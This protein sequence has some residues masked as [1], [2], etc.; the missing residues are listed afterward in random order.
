MKNKKSMKMSKATASVAKTASAAVVAG[1]KNAPAA[2]SSSSDNRF[3]LHAARFKQAPQDVKKVKVDQRF[4]KMFT[5][6]KF[7]EGGSGGKAAVDSRGRPL[8]KEVVNE[9]NGGDR[10]NKKSRGVSSS[11]SQGAGKMK[12]KESSN[13]PINRQLQKFYAL[14][15]ED[16]AEK[17]SS[18]EEEEEE[19][20][21]EDSV[22]ELSEGGNENDAEEIATDDESGSEAGSSDTD[23]SE[24]EDSYDPDDTIWETTGYYDGKQIER[25]EHD[26]GSRLAF[27]TLDWDTVTA[28]DIF[29]V[30]KSFIA[31]SGSRN[32]STGQSGA[33]TRVGKKLLNAGKSSKGETDHADGENSNLTNNDK[34]LY[35]RI[36]RS[37]TGEKALE[38]EAQHGP[39]IQE[40]K[41][42]RNTSSSSATTGK[43][44]QAKEGAGAPVEDSDD[45]EME[46]E[47]DKEIN[48]DIN[49]TND[50]NDSSSSE[51]EE[52]QEE[53]RKYNL[54][55]LQYFFAVI[56]LDSKETCGKLYEE[57]DGHQID[58]LC[59]GRPLDV[60][61]VPDEMGEIDRPVVDECTSKA[62]EETLH[63]SSHN[64][65]HLTENQSLRAGLAHTKAQC[66]WDEQP[67]RRKK[68][69]MK[70]FSKKE[71]ALNDLQTYLADSDSEEDENYEGGHLDE[72]EQNEHDSAVGI[73]TSSRG[74]KNGNAGAQKKKKLSKEVEEKRKLLLGG[75][76]KNAEEEDAADSSPENDSSENNGSEL[77]EEE[78]S[79]EIDLPD[80]AAADKMISAEEEDLPV[81][82]EE[83][84]EEEDD[85][86]P[87]DFSV[88]AS[89]AEN[90]TMGAMEMTFNTETEAVAK[91]VQEKVDEQLKKNAGGK[92]NLQNMQSLKLEQ[93]SKLTPWQKFQE[94]KKEKRREKKLEIK[95]KREEI[96]K[97]MQEELEQQSITAMKGKT[98]K[99][100]KKRK[101]DDDS[102][103]EDFISDVDATQEAHST[104]K[105]STATKEL[106]SDDRFAKL[107]NDPEFGIDPTRPEFND[108][109][110]MRAV[111]V[112]KRK[113]AAKSGNRGKKNAASGASVSTTSSKPQSANNPNAAAATQE[114]TPSSSGAITTASKKRQRGEEAVGEKGGEKKNKF[115]LFS[116]K[117]KRG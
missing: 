117:Q 77:E 54:R 8:K 3:N 72:D 99:K 31:N 102:S 59:N 12:M 46:N 74:E 5:E 4:A 81:L 89:D 57:L 71:M 13:K 6:E 18:D 97:A 40:M 11:I 21:V 110:T 14:E 83:E 107:F 7:N 94:K 95:D 37:E 109:K 88:A 50:D 45:E 79:S 28:E 27:Q 69:L 47:D 32:A 56:Q 15:R 35:C 105:S 30:A 106:A 76:L 16:K 93:A 53:I 75:L 66:N 87:S 42:K 92:K 51:N 64:T 52:Q 20:N 25:T 2:S 86:I 101:N 103:E 62:F 55:K 68:D 10:K 116:K 1:G 91:K 70:K 39:A 84:E 60:R 33:N 22:E 17:V 113:V 36:Y 104:T 41:K 63:K 9:V 23:W 58:S 34:I 82:E 43:N 26:T 114:S 98:K 78:G 24:S 112:E 85:D 38:Y 100:G 29:R 111:L 108:T 67:A 19:E 115:Q 48:P 49:A 73:S 96:K 80:T 61:Q 44:K 65:A 90:E